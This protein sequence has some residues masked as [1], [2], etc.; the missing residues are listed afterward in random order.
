MQCV[1][2]TIH[3]TYISRIVERNTGVIAGDGILGDDL[4]KQRHPGRGL[5][6]IGSG[7]G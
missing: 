5:R 1:Y 3:K 2:R 6:V 7:P 4:A